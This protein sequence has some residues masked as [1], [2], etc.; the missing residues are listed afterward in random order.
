MLRI[1]T[2]S[3]SRQA[4]L[5]EPI[6]SHLKNL[7]LKSI[8]LNAIQ[9]GILH[10]SVPL[11]EGFYKFPGLFGKAEVQVKPNTT[12]WLTVS[13]GKD[14]QNESVVSSVSIKMHPAVKIKNPS[15][16]Y[17]APAGCLNGFKDLFGRIFIDGIEIS[18]TGEVLFQGIIKKAFLKED[19]KKE[20]KPE[21]LPKLDMRLKFLGVHKDSK[22]QQGL[23]KISIPDVLKQFESLL[24]EVKCSVKIRGNT[25]IQTE[26]GF[27]QAELSVHARG[28]VGK[29]GEL[30]I[31]RD[32]QFE[33]KLEFLGLAADLTGE[34]QVSDWVALKP[35]LTGRALA[36]LP[37]HPTELVLDWKNRAEVPFSMGGPSNLVK[38]EAE[39]V[40]GKPVKISGDVLLDVDIGEVEP[41]LIKSLQVKFK[42][43]LLHL[44]GHAE[45]QGSQNA[46]QGALKAEISHPNWAWKKVHAAIPGAVD[47]SIQTSDLEHGTVSYGIRSDKLRPFYRSLGYAMFPKNR[48]ALTPHNTGVSE[49]LDPER[50]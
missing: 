40:P 36:R 1:S 28:R 20:F 27:S 13:L 11:K 10:L 42:K 29:G 14:A 6:K 5:L 4:V 48:L 9:D 32:E 8:D 35:K 45:K 21:L 30:E 23:E 33:N 12:A 3:S 39:F 38:A 43:A 24:G 44:E 18:P 2:T 16:A 50:Q 41:I 49:F 47:F 34:A 37:V 26:A 19:I 46:V 22:H 7:D 17:E 25:P 15:T 31:R